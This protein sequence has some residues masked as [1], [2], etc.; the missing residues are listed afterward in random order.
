ME[1]QNLS[2]RSNEME[3][4]NLPDERVQNRVIKMLMEFRRRM[5]EHRENFNKEKIQEYTKQK[6]QR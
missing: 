2:K 3:I 6:S 4:S 5:D 1:K